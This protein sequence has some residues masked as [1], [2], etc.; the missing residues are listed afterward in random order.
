MRKIRVRRYVRKDGT[1]VR[2]HTRS[3]KSHKFQRFKDYYQPTS[4]THI[5]R[6]IKTTIQLMNSFPDVTTLTCCAGHP[7]RKDVVGEHEI[8][9]RGYISFIAEENDAQ[10]IKQLA[11]ESK[12]SVKK[13]PKI[14]STR[15]KFIRELQFEQKPEI[16]DITQKTDDHDEWMEKL[17]VFNKL[18]RK[19]LRTRGKHK[20]Q[21]DPYYIII[22]DG[23][24]RELTPSTHKTYGR[25]E[26]N[27]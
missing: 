7:Y 21:I 18:M 4:S 23:E 8:T 10:I 20:K 17:K 2:A 14:S 3:L 11:R 16:Y 26:K 22:V 19:E 24:K 1:L 15:Y 9:P 12:L 6:D 25:F 13:N 5:D 27:I